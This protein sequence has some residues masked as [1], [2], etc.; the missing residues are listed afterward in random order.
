MK[1]TDKI[2]LK[3]FWE[4]VE[5]RLAA[6]STDELCA[7]LRAMAQETSPSGRRVFLS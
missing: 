7:I 4:S 5:Q 1:H 2:S 3:V 6:C